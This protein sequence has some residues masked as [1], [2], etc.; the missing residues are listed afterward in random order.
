LLRSQANAQGLSRRPT[1]ERRLVYRVVGD[2]I[3]FLQVRYHY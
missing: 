2:R 3:D 1:Q